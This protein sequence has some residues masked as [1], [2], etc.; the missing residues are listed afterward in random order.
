M[1]QR[2]LAELAIGDA[3][4]GGTF[5]PQVVHFW[6]GDGLGD[7]GTRRMR[8]FVLDTYRSWTSSRDLAASTAGPALREASHGRVGESCQ[9]CSLRAPSIQ[10]VR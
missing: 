4:R 9:S 6:C 7:A 1:L 10:D 2:K 8:R 5:R 3:A